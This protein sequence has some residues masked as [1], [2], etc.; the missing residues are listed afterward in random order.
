[1]AKKKADVNKS[2]EIRTFM[3]SNPKAKPREV[4]AALKER[5]IDVSAQFVS[6]VK[7]NSVKGVGTKR[8]GRPAGSTKRAAAAAK[9]AA[10]RKSGG[11]VSVDSLLKVK[12]VVKELGSIEETKAALATLEQLAD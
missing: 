7:S 3:E 5:G 6:T 12:R 2:L 1:M 10:T 11:S 4:V 8:R 9:P